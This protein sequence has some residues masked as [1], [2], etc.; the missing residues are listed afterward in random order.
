MMDGGASVVAASGI[1]T[2]TLITSVFE[3]ASHQSDAVLLSR[4]GDEGDH[5]FNN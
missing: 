1:R 5:R 2:G 4:T 3:S